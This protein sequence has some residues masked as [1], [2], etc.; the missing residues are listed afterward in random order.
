MALSPRP[1]LAAFVGPP[2]I[3]LSVLVIFAP[4][5]PGLPDEN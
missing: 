5:L 4:G 1:L 2:L 3:F